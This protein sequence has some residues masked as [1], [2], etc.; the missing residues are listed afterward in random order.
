MSIHARLDGSHFDVV[1]THRVLMIAVARQPGD[2]RGSC[3]HVGSSHIGWTERNV[4]SDKH[5]TGRVATCASVV[6]DGAHTDAVWLQQ[7]ICMGQ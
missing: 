1:D 3:S 6:G 5:G 4:F 2:E 7:Q